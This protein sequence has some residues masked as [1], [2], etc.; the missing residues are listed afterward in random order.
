[1]PT[2]VDDTEL[3]QTNVE[4]NYAADF[5]KHTDHLIYLTGKVVQVKPHFLNI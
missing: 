2:I 1:M 3:D 4:F 5:V